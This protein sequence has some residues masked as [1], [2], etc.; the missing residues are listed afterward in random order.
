MG[1]GVAAAGGLGLPRW[2]ESAEAWAG[3]RLLS[4]HSH[5]IYLPPPSGHRGNTFGA[6]KLS[7]GLEDDRGTAA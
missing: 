4:W 2:L 5:L 7:G 1:A 3:G 6:L